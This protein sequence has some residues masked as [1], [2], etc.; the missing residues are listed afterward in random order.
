[1]N[2]RHGGFSWVIA[3]DGYDIGSTCSITE[4]LSWERWVLSTE[5][6]ELFEY[7]ENVK[8][9]K[10]DLIEPIRKGGDK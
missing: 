8:Y 7:V 10:E 3:V 5:L 2:N 1:M 9:G 6:N 4:C